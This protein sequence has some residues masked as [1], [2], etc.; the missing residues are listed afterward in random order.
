MDWIFLFKMSNSTGSVNADQ[1]KID[2]D[3]GKGDV[4]NILQSNSS[5]NVYYRKVY[6]LAYK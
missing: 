4:C 2:I 6:K 5:F 3:E 1:I